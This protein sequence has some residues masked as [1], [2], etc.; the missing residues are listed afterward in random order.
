MTSAE[1]A[2]AAAYRA[3]WGRLLALLLARTRRLDLVEDGLAEAF[4]QGAARW[5]VHG[6]PANPSGW[7]YTVANRQIIDAIRAEEVAARKAPLVAVRPGWA[8]P[9]DAF[10]DEGLPDDRLELIVLCCHP[11][12]PLASRSALALR[13]VMG[14]PTEQIA[15]LFLVTTPTMAARLTR[16]KRKIVQAGIPL[17][18][19]MDVAL[20]ARLDEVCHTVYLAFTAGYT[21]GSGP[22]LLRGDLAGEAVRLARIL[23]DLTPT[24]PQVGALLALLTLQHSRRDARVSQG[25][26]VTLA[27]QDRGTWHHEEIEVGLALMAQLPRT[28][29]YAEELR[30]QALIAAEHARAPS[31]AQTDWPRIATR[32]AEL[33]AVTGSPWVRLNRAVALAEADSPRSGLALLEGLADQFVDQH[34]FW[35]V[36]ADLSARTGATDAALASYERA[37]ALCQ[38]DVE[39]RHLRSRAADLPG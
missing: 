11:A 27:E 36:H 29:G 6:I 31:A 28:Q 26:L 10:G 1:Q 35:A 8:A 2:L 19:P 16:A 12:L 13:L 32:Y 23:H 17:G 37:I 25:S 24:A 7:L 18:V 9:I 34:R 5:P 38:N 22:E 4:A 20:T 39:R 3:D 14:T 15:R 30:L 33:E 21:P